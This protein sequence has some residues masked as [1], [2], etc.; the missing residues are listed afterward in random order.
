MRDADAIPVGLPAP[1]NP[2]AGN[3]Y[4]DDAPPLPCPERPTILV[5]EPNPILA[6]ALC[7]RIAQIATLACDRLDPAAADLVGVCRDN[8]CRVILIDPDN[9]NMAESEF[10]AQLHAL[11]PGTRVVGYGAA[12]EREAVLD[13]LGAGFCG[14][15]SKAS[16]FEEV[17]LAVSA[18]LAGAAFVGR[19]CLHALRAVPRAPKVSLD[20]LATL[21][22]REREVFLGTARGLTLKQ[23]AYSMDVNIKTVSTYKTRACGKLGLRDRAAVTEFCL[24]HALISA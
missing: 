14:Y 6:G 12:T 11:D 20:G 4:E 22:A 2:R 8:A 21:S 9:I 18:A 10:V 13:A 24:S 1:C 3:W 23:I 17:A 19:D 15:V 7:E 16:P 5:A